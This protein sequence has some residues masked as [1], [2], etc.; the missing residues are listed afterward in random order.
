MFDKLVNN[1][2][3]LTAHPYVVLVREKD[4]ISG[5]GAQRT[6]EI[7][8]VTNIIGKCVKLYTLVGDALRNRDR[9]IARGIVCNNQFV[10][11]IEVCKNAFELL[12][13]ESLT[14][15]ARQAYTDFHDATTL[16]GQSLRNRIQGMSAC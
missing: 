5:G 13:K 1:S 16:Q 9:A 7:A 14:I 3:A 2:I 12:L 8:N 10:T 11:F 6:L 4:H 15:I